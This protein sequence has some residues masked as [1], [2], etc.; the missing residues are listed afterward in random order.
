MNLLPPTDWNDIATTADVEGASIAM[1]SDMATLQS[2]LQG[3]MVELR[4][5]LR[6]EIGELRSELR[7]EI[8]VLRGEIAGVRVELAEVKGEFFR[9][10]A[11][12]NFVAVLTAVGLVLAAMRI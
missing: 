10:M 4:S 7:G 9:N 5:E 1:R 3:E 11:L 12:T 2:T 8:G 6:G